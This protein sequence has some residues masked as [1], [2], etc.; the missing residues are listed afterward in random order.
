MQINT[1]MK[2]CLTAIRM[3]KIK[4]SRNDK[5]WQGC[6]ERNYWCECQLVQPLW[7]TVQSFL[8]KLKTELPFDPVIPLDIYSK[9]LKT[10][11]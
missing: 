3:A 10:V 2:N 1:E 4:N 6:E 5:C 11:I 9:N 8:R 7:K